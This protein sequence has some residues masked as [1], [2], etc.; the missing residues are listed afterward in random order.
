MKLYLLLFFNVLLFINVSCSPRVQVNTEPAAADFHLSNYQT[1]AFFDVDASGEA[2]SSG[3]QQQVEYMKSEIAQQLQ[4]RGLTPATDQ[5][6]LLINLGIVVNEE[7]QTRETNIVTDP[8]Q[9]IGQRRYT[10]RSREVEVGRYREGT[11]SVHLVDNAQNELVWRG[12]AEGVLPRKSSEIQEQI[13]EG[14]EKL[15]SKV[16]Q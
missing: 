9:Y 7:V 8:P 4:R 5:P 13:A 15:F 10:W 6:D 2:L 1:F 16:P 3:Y 12:T 11:V 14:V